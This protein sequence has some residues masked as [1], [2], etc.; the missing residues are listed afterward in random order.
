MIGL[1][2]ENSGGERGGAGAV[3]TPRLQTIEECGNC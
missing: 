1:M 2:F 3:Q